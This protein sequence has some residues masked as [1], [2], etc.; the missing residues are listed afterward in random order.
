MARVSPL[1][2]LHD[3]AE[4]ETLPY[5]APETSPIE[6]VGT[7]GH[8]ELEYAAI[9]RGS[10]LIDQPQ[11]ATMVV[12]GDDAPDFLA[13]M[14]TQRLDD[15]EPWRARRSFWL[16]QKGRIDADLRV[17]RLSDAFVL[18]VDAHAAART[19][20]TL[21]AYVI[22]EDV[23]IADE[24]ASRHRFALH[25]PR[26]AGLLQ[27]CAEDGGN[28][29][30]ALEDGFVAR[31]VI[32]GAEVIADRQDAL[33]SPGYELHMATEEAERVW[34][35]LCEV[36]LPATEEEQSTEHRLRP[37]G[38]H[39]FNTARV[40]AGWPL[41]YLDFGPN[42]L[43]HETGVVHDRVSFTKGC[44]LGQ[45]VVARMESRGRGKQ[46]LVAIRID[47]PPHAPESGRPTQPITG[48]AVLDAEDPTGAPIGVVTSSVLSPM[49]GDAP[50]CFAQVK[51]ARGDAG[52]LV[53]VEAQGARMPGE[54]RASLNFLEKAPSAG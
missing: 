42:S 32:G 20:E 14:L 46:C 22:G 27:A 48:E 3:N 15:L 17:L 51:R 25:G 7:F 44:F 26:A 18:D 35:R 43:P 28:A 33:G 30:G 11:R 49:L 16:N 50:I 23:T 8:L 5:A 13:R 4:A 29:I 40:E 9:R 34:Q 52:T 45:E 10:A 47:A 54:V 36:G 1:R 31:C 53:L 37:A 19:R 6:I 12:T 41:Y 39:A 38:W 24:T 2:N 21:D